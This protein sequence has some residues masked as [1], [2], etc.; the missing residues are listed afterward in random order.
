MHV[1][2]PLVHASM[3]ATDKLRRWDGRSGVQQRVLPAPAQGFHCCIWIVCWWQNGRP[4]SFVNTDSCRWRRILEYFATFCVVFG[5]FTIRWCKKV[6]L[7]AYVCLCLSPNVTIQDLWNL[8]VWG[9]RK[10]YVNR[11]VPLSFEHSFKSRLLLC[12]AVSKL[13]D[14][15]G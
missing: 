8:L 7:L 12:S 3:H 15:W 9:E 13:F 10:I 1:C 5:V 2:C 14:A 11:N 6:D 4:L